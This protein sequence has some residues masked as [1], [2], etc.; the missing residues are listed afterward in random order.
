MK[1]ERA[2]LARPDEGGDMAPGTVLET[3]V[4]VVSTGAGQVL[5]EP[6]EASGCGACQARAACGIG[7]L[8]RVLQPARRPIAV[9]C[10]HPVRAGEELALTVAAG[11]LLRAAL[12]AY[13]LPIVLGVAAA[14]VVS[15]QGL[16]EAAAAIALIAGAGGG[17]LI[18]R[19]LGRNAPMLARPVSHP[20][21][22][23]E[24]S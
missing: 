19:R 1:P 10:A 5:V 11:D 16:S 21:V 23:G 18:A 6:L 22:K 17:L 9:S 14:G 13:L 20:P 24:T 7:G 3:R 12:L 8:A 4:R 15:A 2:S